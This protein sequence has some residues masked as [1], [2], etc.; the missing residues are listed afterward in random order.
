ME[1][2][3]Y[4]VFNRTDGIFATDELF[5]SVE[6]AKEFIKEFRNRFKAQGYY[7]DSR[8]NKIEPENIELE[9]CEL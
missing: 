8:W 6:S 3:Q 7:R 4:Q 5:E 1:I 2:E 9:I